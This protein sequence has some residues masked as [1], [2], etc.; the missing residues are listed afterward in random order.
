MI[1]MAVYYLVKGPMGALG[2]DGGNFLV[3]KLNME[4]MS[5]AYAMHK[6][7]AEAGKR[8]GKASAGPKVPKKQMKLK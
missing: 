4:K 5:F 2:R 6:E 8:K 7:K 1:F 3:G